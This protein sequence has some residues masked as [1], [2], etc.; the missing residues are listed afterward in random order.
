MDNIRENY[1]N[2]FSENTHAFQLITRVDNTQDRDEN[3]ALLLSS[4]IKKDPLKAV[5]SYLKETFTEKFPAAIAGLDP[6]IKNITKADLFNQIL[7]FVSKSLPSHCLKCET[8]YIPYSQD[9]STDD[10]IKCF[11]CKLPAH[12]ECYTTTDVNF[13]LVFLCQLCL[14]SE[15]KEPTIEEEKPTESEDDE[16][17][18]EKTSVEEVSDSTDTE[19]EREVWKIKKKKSRKSKVQLE[20]PKK[21]DQVC[22]LLI[23]GICPHGISGKQCEY[24]HKSICYKYCAFGTKEM[25]KGGCRFGE[26]CRY[27]HPTLCQNSVVTGLCLNEGCKNAHLRDTRRNQ[28]SGGREK[29]TYQKSNTQREHN[30]RQ[31]GYRQQYRRE[32]P[33][34]E[35]SESHP[36]SYSSNGRWEKGLQTNNQQDFLSS[37]MER[38]QKELSNQIQKEIR[39]QFQTLQLHQNQGMPEYNAEYPRIQDP[40]NQTWNAESQW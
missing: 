2:L 32:A 33:R 7:D 21:K 29:S 8:E 24:K 19:N 3:L 14:K 31:G 22:P 37:M 5:V 27:L 16:S 6:K 25:H 28:Q 10:D 17:D 36:T 39:M 40:A 12:R 13:H 30:Y 38:I 26:N 1:N 34:Y 35:Q 15:K 23:E 11:G 4:S 9:N 18:N 20:K